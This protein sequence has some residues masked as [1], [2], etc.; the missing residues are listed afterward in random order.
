MTNLHFRYEKQFVIA[1]KLQVSV[2]VRPTDPFRE[3]QR[4]VAVLDAQ[5]S[6][7]HCPCFSFAH[8]MAPSI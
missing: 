3:S 5:V 1:L 7:F 2:R 6:T 4:A 8:I